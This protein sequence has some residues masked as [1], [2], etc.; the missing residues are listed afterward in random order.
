MDE[1]LRIENLTAGYHGKPIIEDIDLTVRSGAVMAV[2]GE[3][4]SG[5]STLLR[6]ILQL[7]GMRPDMYGGRVR[8]DGRDMALLSDE[9]RRRLAG[10]SVSMLFQQAEASLNPSRTIRA[11]LYEFVAS[12]VSMTKRDIDARAAEIFGRLHLHDAER[13]MRSYPFELSGGMAQRTAMMMAVFLRPKLLLADEPTSAL[14]ATVQK[15]VVEEL[16]MLRRIY[17]MSIVIVTHNIGVAKRMA[18]EI[19]VMRGGRIVECGAAEAVLTAPKAAY[20][21]ALLAAVP[22]LDLHSGGEEMRS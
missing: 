5:K 13:I 6:A 16:L 19:V 8:F 9:E 11:Q 21:K 14:D 3:S 20:T 1:L 18:D 2:V 15:Q 17:D 22:S 7:K 10:Q 12:H 4:G